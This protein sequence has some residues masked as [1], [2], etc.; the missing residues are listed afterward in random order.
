MTSMPRSRHV[1]TSLALALALA[2]LALAPPGLAKKTD[3]QQE[4]HVDAQH[5]DGFQK[6]NS[7]STLS[8]D[9]S[10]VQGTLKASGSKAEVHFDGAGEISRVVITGFPARIEQLDDHGNLVQGQARTL[11]YDNI[12]GIAVL[13]GQA[14]ILQKGRGSASGDRLTYDTG[15]SEMTGESGGDGRVHMTFKPK[16]APPTNEP[17]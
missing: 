6:P 14:L 10:I 12:K 1:P 5:F 2:G 3:R 8:G 4:M 15:T 13:A 16:S 9:V 7:V 11:D 17:G